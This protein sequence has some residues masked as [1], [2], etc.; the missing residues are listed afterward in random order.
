MRILFLHP[1]FPSQ[2]RHLAAKLGEDPRNQVVFG[3]T[4]PEGELP[5]VQK[6]GYKL[7]REPRPETHHYLRSLEL[8]VLHGQAAFRMGVNLRKQGFIPDIVYAHSGW[9]TSLFMKDAFPKSTF[10]CQFEWFYRAHGSDSD[11]DPEETLT[12]DDEARIRMKNAGILTDLYSCDGGTSPTYW[13]KQQFPTEYQSKIAVL[14]EGIDTDYFQ[15]RPGKLVLPRIGLDLSAAEE[16]VT[17]VGR[18]MEPYRGFP[19]FI[20]AVDLLLRQRPRAHVVIVGEDRVCYG[21]KLPRGQSFKKQMLAKYDLDPERVHFTGPLPYDEYL[22]VLQAS[23]AHVY[24]TRPFVLSWSMM[25]AMSVGCLVVASRTAPVIEVIEDGFNGLL[26]D[27]FS[28]EDLAGRI[29]EALQHRARFAA[30]R[31][32]ARDTVLHRYSLRELLPRRLEWLMK[33]AG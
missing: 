26:V 3:T 4:A 18:G 22:Q 5:G 7:A 23:D 11:F 6:V 9:G 1:N 30:V 29:A 28:P 24:L 33:F 31:K 17:Y 19:Q 13:Q 14:H 32:K 25:E 8:A 16:V 21:R 12:V 20:A 10:L 27:F 2:F 15:P